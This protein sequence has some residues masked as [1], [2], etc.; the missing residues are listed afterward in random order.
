MSEKE[1]CGGKTF[2]EVIEEVE[3]HISDKQRIAK[4]E[5]E[6]EQ[7]KLQ[8]EIVGDRIDSLS[9]TNIALSNKIEKIRKCLDKWYSQ[10]TSEGYTDYFY[11]CLLEETKSFLFTDVNGR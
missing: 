3:F 4:L 9:S 2:K 11:K 6:N 5:E 8:L 10:Y 1:L 7:L